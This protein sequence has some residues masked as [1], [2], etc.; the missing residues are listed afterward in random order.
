[1]DR[2]KNQNIRAGFTLIELLVVI[3]IIGLLASIALIALMQAR[4]KGRDAKRIGD[5]TQMNNALELYFS[6]YKGYPSETNGIPHMSSDT[7]S[8]IP[9]S[10]NPADGVCEGLSH[11]PTCAASDPS[12]TGVPANRYYYIPSGTAFQG[13]TNGPMVYGDYNYYF[14]LGNQTGNFASGERVL[15]PTGV[16]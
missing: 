9:A 10:P 7:I 6:I 3:A 2:N 14:C 16:R 13:I 11:N 12:C 1:M 8:T 15:N 4:Q 5:M